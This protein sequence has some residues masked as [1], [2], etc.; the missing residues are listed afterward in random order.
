M[1]TL[2]NENCLIGYFRKLAA[3]AQINAMNQIEMEGLW[4]WSTQKVKDCKQ[5]GKK[6]DTDGDKN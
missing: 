5:G 3:L 6:K 2:S 4:L 1:S